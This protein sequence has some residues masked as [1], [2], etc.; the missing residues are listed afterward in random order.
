MPFNPSTQG[1]RFFEN[2]GMYASAWIMKRKVKRKFWS[3]ELK[4]DKGF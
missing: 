4:A 3:W 2:Q 1:R